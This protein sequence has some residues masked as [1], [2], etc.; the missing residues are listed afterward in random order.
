MADEKSMADVADKTVEHIASGIKGLADAV[1]KVAPHAWS[2]A[3]R[4]QVVEAWT[5]LAL[6]ALGLV[7]SVTIA[8]VVAKNYARWVHK[9]R[10]NDH[11]EDRIR[12][13]SIT[14]L[15]MTGFEDATAA[16]APCFI[17]LGAAFILFVPCLISAA[18]HVNQLCNPEYYAAKTLLGAVR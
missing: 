8:V 12:Y 7:V 10:E 16:Q 17:A 9:A 6:C 5:G 11:A 3:V 4:Q 2:V 18:D 14:P 15:E 1:Q 13:P